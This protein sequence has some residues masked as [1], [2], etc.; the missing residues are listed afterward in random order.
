MALAFEG[1]S[2]TSEYAFPLMLM[3]TIMG[4]WDRTS[5]L[6]RNT[7][8]KLAQGT[9]SS[10]IAHRL[11]SFTTPL[12]SHLII[13][14]F[15]THNTSIHPLILHT[16]FLRCT[17]IADRDL[18]HSFLTFNTC[19]KDTGLFGVYLVCSDTNKLD[20]AIGL[21]MEHLVRLCHDVSDDEVSHSFLS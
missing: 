13:R 5:P 8:S 19:Y 4:S 3:Q 6:G 12:H 21:T 10:S 20:E 16:Q 14:S 15:L 18:A 1:A 2:W 11:R 7:A 17:E 9:T